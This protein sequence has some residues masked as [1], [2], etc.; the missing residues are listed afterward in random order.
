MTWI[1]ADWRC[2]FHGRT[3][4]DDVLTALEERV[5]PVQALPVRFQHLLLH[6]RQHDQCAAIHALYKWPEA[7]KKP[8]L[9]ETNL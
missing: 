2:I 8:P 6:E 7:M 1:R 9:Y 5:K 4:I 3:S